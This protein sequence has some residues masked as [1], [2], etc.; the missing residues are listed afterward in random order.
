[1]ETKIYVATFIGQDS[2]GY[3]R[4]R[5]YEIFVQPQGL[6]RQFRKGWAIEIWLGNGIGWCPYTSLHSFLDNW[7]IHPEQKPNQS[8]K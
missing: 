4:G 3:V 2:L 5:T 1:M 7:E 6:W 8:L